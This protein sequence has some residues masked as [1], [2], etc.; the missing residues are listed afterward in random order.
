MNSE[1]AVAAAAAQ[2]KKARS[3]AIFCHSRPDGDSLG[4]GLALCLAMRAAGKTAYLVCEDAAPEK[5]LFIPAMAEIKKELPEGEFDTFIAVDCADFTRMG[6]FGNVF[7]RFRGDTVNIDHHIS[8]TEYAKTNCVCVCSATCEIMPRV[9]DAA[10]LTIS[11]PVAN[12]LMLG[13]VTDSGSF[14]H[15]DVTGHTFEVAARLR[16]AGADITKINY[17][18]FS[19]QKKARALLF[20]RAL[21]NLRFA[22]DD[23]LAFI[24]VT[25]AALKETGA[26]RSLTEGFVDYPLSIDGVEVSIALLEM[27]SGQYKA[28]LRSKGKVNVNAVASTFGGGG[29]ILASGCMLFGEYEEVVERLTYAVYQ[30]L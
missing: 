11:E 6:A 10:G 12:L 17:E 20:V 15:S 19:R 2:I 1:N 30:H 5:F 27:K 9:L 25:D 21:N 18:M 14:A 28:S 13:L 22:L 29:H 26:E 23:K 4:S 24:L 3:A 7:A 16:D 8:N